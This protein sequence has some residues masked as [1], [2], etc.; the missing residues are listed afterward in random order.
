MHLSVYNDTG[1]PVESCCYD[2]PHIEKVLEAITKNFPRYFENFVEGRTARNFAK[3]INE[4]IAEFESDR[5]TYKEIFDEEF[6]EE[7][8]DDPNAFKSNILKN[9][10]PIIRKTLQSAKTD[11]AL[12][13]YRSKFN[14]AD[15][16][17]LLEKVTTICR[18]GYDCFRDPKKLSE[19]AYLDTEDCSVYGVI[20]GGIK[21]MF[22]YKLYPALFPSRSKNALWALYFLS[23]KDKFG[24]DYDSEFLMIDDVKKIV[25]QQNYFYPY[26]LFYRYACEIYDLLER[27]AA[28]VSFSLPENYRYVAVDAFFSSV[29]ENHENEIK[30]YENQIRDGG[31]DY[32]WA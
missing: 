25:T 5:D 3:V 18:F 32:A 12:A 19:I 7:Y 29:A 21:T 15:A 2:E 23:G 24:C 4:A 13:K 1:E 22:L 31:S 8:E 26:E 17:E 16:N 30:F 10:C 9:K 6:L 28:E 27:E 11:K 20:G 14:C